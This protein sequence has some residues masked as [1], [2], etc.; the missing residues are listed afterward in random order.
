MGRVN[1]DSGRRG[2][3]VYLEARRQFGA[4]LSEIVFT[5]DFLGLW[6]S[7]THAVWRVTTLQ[8][9]RC[10]EPHAGGYR[11]ADQVQLEALGRTCQ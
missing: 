5:L 8:L 9:E 2:H 4:H 11:L 7:S 6:K 10:G 1:F 3:T